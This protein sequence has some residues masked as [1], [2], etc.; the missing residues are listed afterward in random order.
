MSW[1]VRR[2]L[3]LRV[4]F[5]FVTLVYI[6]AVPSTSNAL[7]SEQKK[8]F[9]S[10]IYHFDKDIQAGTCSVDLNGSLTGG[11][12]PE[13]A[14]RYLMSKG[15]LEPAQAAGIVGN[16]MWESGG[17]D[18]T[19]SRNN[20]GTIGIAQW[21]GNRDDALKAFAEKQGKD[22]QDLGVQLDYLWQ[23]LNTTEKAAL[24]AVLATHTPKDAAIA[25]EEK[26]ERAGD[27][28]MQD[29]INNAEEIMTKYGSTSDNGDTNTVSVTS[30]D[31]SSATGSGQPSQYVDGFAI[32]SQYDKRWADRPYGTSTI[33]ESG[34]GPSAMA[35]IIT[36]L[37]GK[38][39]TPIETTN[40][41]NTKNLY[42]SGA[43]SSWSIAP[44][45]A[46]KWGLHAKQIGLDVT[47]INAT[48]RAGGLVIGSGDGPK[49]FTTSGHY[50]V[51]RAVTPDGK[52]L[53][54]DSAHKDTNT[55]AYTPSQ[56]Y[57]YLHDGSVYA[58]TK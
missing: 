42:I 22:W 23:E 27:P 36:A 24:D 50:I 26:F 21:E 56:I 54:G 1:L 46:E 40:Y 34:C 33:A 18:P 3:I 51:I 8:Y 35:M 12:N 2:N 19:S 30:S 41:A 29:R 43:G 57:T 55:I 45:L 49:P 31:C 48:L 9:Q 17:V 39:V 4:G 38:S 47:T 53:V 16:L 14:F 10:G 13:K 52:W 11:D 25:F 44:V 6:L 15:V 7:S 20:G 32:Y 28:R 37:T 58:I 5:L